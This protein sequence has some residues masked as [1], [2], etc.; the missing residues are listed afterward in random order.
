MG[1]INTGDTAWVLAAA[2][3][4]LFMTPGLA[5]FYG[6]LVRSKNVLATMMQSFAAIAVVSIAWLAIGYTL[7]F[8]PD[9]GLVIGGLDFA[10]FRGVGAEPM[11]LAPTIPASTFAIYQLMFAII[12]P[13]LS[14]GACAERVLFSGYLLFITDWSILVY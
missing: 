2:A 3:L 11:A 5:L 1:E 9:M 8:G 4:V 13:A 10:G 6:G 7:A 12:T 14:D